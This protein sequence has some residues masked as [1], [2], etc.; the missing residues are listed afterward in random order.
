MSKGRGALAEWQKRLI[1]EFF[2]HNI[3]IEACLIL[4]GVRSCPTYRQNPLIKTW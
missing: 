4:L 2:R 3:G 1:L